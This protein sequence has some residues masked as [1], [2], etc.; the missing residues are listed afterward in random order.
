[1]A[2][3]AEKDLYK[4]CRWEKVNLPVVVL[5]CKIVFL[6]L[7][8]FTFNVHKLLLVG[9]LSCEI[10]TS[11]LDKPPGLPKKVV[12][13]ITVSWPVVTTE[14]KRV[15]VRVSIRANSCS[16]LTNITVTSYDF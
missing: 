4:C 11:T 14:M 3:E 12:L 7:A 15:M 8:Q 1:M 16:F 6:H 10:K 9:V 2:P 13:L 5:Q